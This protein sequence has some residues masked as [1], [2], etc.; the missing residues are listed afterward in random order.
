ME[1]R[2]VNDMFGYCKTEPDSMRMVSDD[3]LKDAQR[4]SNGKA[5]TGNKCTRNF[6][7]CGNFVK[8]SEKYQPVVIKTK[9]A[10]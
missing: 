10:A 2:C 5:I 6:K 8:S 4:T 9:K 1:W 3:E 7:T